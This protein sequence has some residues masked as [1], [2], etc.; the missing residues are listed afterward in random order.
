[1]AGVLGKAGLVLALVPMLS[2]GRMISKFG[3]RQQ[4]YAAMATAHSLLVVR[5]LRVSAAGSP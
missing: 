2:V 3:S 1:M 5:V 4:S